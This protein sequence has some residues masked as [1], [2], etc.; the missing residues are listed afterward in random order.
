MHE[1]ISNSTKCFIWSSRCREVNE[2]NDVASG[3]AG[4]ADS[5]ISRMSVPKIM[6]LTFALCHKY[7]QKLQI[8]KM[9]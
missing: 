3:G 7:F 8:L 4:G 9:S 1:Y 5:P 6:K 2:T